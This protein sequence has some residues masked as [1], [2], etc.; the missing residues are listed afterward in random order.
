VAIGVGYTEPEFVLPLSENEKTVLTRSTTLITVRQEESSYRVYNELDGKAAY[1]LPC[2]ALFCFEEFPQKSNE[3]KFTAMAHS[4]EELN[5]GMYFSSDPH[6]ML[7]EIGQAPVI[8]SDRLH[9]IIAGISSGAECIIVNN[10]NF[11][12]VE[13]LKLFK[14]VLSSEPEEI[15]KFKEKIL[16]IYISIIKNYL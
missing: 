1:S 8:I 16:A 9:G 5:D 12:V 14:E 15:K 13:A 4:I 6:D 10:N 3:S 7:Y 11:R 2:P